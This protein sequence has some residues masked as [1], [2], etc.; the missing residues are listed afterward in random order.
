M[1]THAYNP[2]ECPAHRGPIMIHFFD[3]SASPFSSTD[4]CATLAAGTRT[5]ADLA[6]AGGI[7]TWNDF[8][9]TNNTYVNVHTTAN[10]R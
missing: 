3:N 7:S 10:P 4:G 6:S 1:Q 8:V 5:P 2:Y 9:E